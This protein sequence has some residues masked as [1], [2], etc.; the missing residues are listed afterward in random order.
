MGNI[1]KGAT[2]E[3]IT[4]F[5]AAKNFH[6]KEMSIMKD[7]ANAALNRGFGFFTLENVEDTDRLLFTDMEA[8]QGKNVPL[9]LFLKLNFI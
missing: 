3:Q 1:P 8:F 4:E 6:F 5:F 2:D 9:F 7:P